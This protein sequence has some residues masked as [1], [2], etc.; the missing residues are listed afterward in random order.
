MELFIIDQDKCNRDLICVDTCPI[1]II[2]LKENS[3]VPTPI[4]GAQELCI[5]CGHCVAVCPQGALTHKNMRP[6]Q[7][8]PVL[9]ELLPKPDQVEHFLRARR[10]IRVYTD[11]AV[12][13]KTIDQLINI[14]RF[15]PSGHNFQ[16]VEWLVIYDTNEVKRFVGMVIDW[17][18]HLLNKN[19]PTA[20]AMHMDR[21]VN[22]WDKGIDSVCR[23][24]PHV[25]MTHAPKNNPTAPAACTI[26]LTYL[27]LA[28]ASFELGTCWAGFFN[29]AATVWPPMQQALGLPEEHV[30]YG[31]MMMG[32]PKYGYQRL[33]QRNEAKITWL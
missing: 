24:V 20:K 4:D 26:A 32:F 33:P 10:S 31:S 12:N 19:S 28:A 14:A 15:A 9:K 18:R 8:P 7:C 25:I 23:N 2:E 3:K 5:N 11:K 1:K 29:V 17:M 22:A 30:S 27:E 13:R 6:E 21:V 16:P